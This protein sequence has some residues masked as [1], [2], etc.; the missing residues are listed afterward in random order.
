[1]ATLGYFEARGIPVWLE[2]FLQLFVVTI[3][4]LGDQSSL[5][6]EALLFKYQ[7]DDE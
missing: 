1:M 4:R 5:A 7:P 2:G 6:Y 3:K